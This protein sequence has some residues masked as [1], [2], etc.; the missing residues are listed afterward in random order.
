MVD[1][2][3]HGCLNISNV[4]VVL[5]CK[6]YNK[7][8][9]NTFLYKTKL[10]ILD[11]MS[12]MKRGM[13][14]LLGIMIIIFFCF[15]IPVFLS[16]IN[17]FYG[18]PVIESVTLKA[19]GF[20]ILIFGLS[21][22]IYTVHYHLLTGRVTPVAIERP[23]EFINKGFYKYSRNPMYVAVL[24]TLLG[25]FL[26]FGHLLLLAYVILAIPALHSFVVYKEE[27]ELKKLFG[28][29]YEEYMKK[30]PRWFPAASK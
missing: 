27:P 7:Y 23:R 18:L 6:D 29:E 19:F 10:F 11:I 25:V 16:V 4:F 15:S 17:L 14:L 8:I 30:V 5:H 26:V 3:V 9:A 24:M 21:T 2:N 28:K 13:T 12:L 20:V 22:T 1:E